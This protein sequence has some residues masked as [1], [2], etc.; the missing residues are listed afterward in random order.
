M[1]K[2]IRLCIDV[3]LSSLQQHAIMCLR[4]KLSYR[5][6]LFNIS[7]EKSQNNNQT[8]SSKFKVPLGNPGVPA[9]DHHRFRVLESI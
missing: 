1:V 6:S 7:R 8:G 2:M 4:I 3:W 9:S 5:V